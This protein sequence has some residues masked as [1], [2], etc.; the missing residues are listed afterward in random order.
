MSYRYFPRSYA[1]CFKT[2]LLEPG[3]VELKEVNGNRHMLEVVLNN[4][5]RQMECWRY[6]YSSLPHHGDPDI[7]ESE[8][9]EMYEVLDAVF[10]EVFPTQASL[11]R[12]DAAVYMEGVIR[13]VSAEVSGKELAIPGCKQHLL[14]F[15]EKLLEALEQLAKKPTA[16]VAT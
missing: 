16:E 11:N 10:K 7:P 8:A 4:F 5:F 15:M 12:A 13:S 6:D 3:V 9:K 1:Y 14:I 2:M